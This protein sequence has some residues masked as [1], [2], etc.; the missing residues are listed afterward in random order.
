MNAFELSGYDDWKTTDYDGEQAVADDLRRESIELREWDNVLHA[1]DEVTNGVLSE[2]TLDS[3]MQRI[4]PDIVTAWF[5]YERK[6]DEA[7][8]EPRYDFD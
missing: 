7:R 4:M 2:T 5:E 6:L 8:P 3:I 1:L